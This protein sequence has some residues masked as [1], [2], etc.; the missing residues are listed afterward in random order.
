MKSKPIIFELKGILDGREISPQ[1]L[2]IRRAHEFLGE[3]KEFIF[4]DKNIP[5]AG[6]HIPF[7]YAE[8]SARFIAEVPENFVPTIEHDL[9]GLMEKGEKFEFAVPKRSAVLQKWRQNCQRNP[10]I[11]YGIGTVDTQL[12]CINQETRLPNPVNQPYQSELYLFGRIMEWGGVSTSNIHIKTEEYG[13][14]LVTI[15]PQLLA[16]E[17]TNRVYHE[18]TI[19]VLA[20]Q[21]LLTGEILKAE[22]LEFADYAP[23]KKPEVLAAAIKI[24]T[25]KWSDVPNAAEWVRDLRGEL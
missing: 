4:A 15:E 1:T 21:N 25:L 19:R 20:T 24:G 13:T 18:A 10:G 3:V 14:V 11:E 22:F 16:Q 17:E 8:G 5:T 7:Q 12:S 2:D 9:N 23:G 6:V